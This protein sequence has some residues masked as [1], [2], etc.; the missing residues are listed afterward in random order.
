VA[1]PAELLFATEIDGDSLLD[2]DP[3]TAAVAVVGALGSP[4]VASL[5]YDEDTGVLYGTDTL[6]DNLVS[7]DPMT[8]NTTVVGDMHLGL[9]HASAIEPVDGTLYVVSLEQDLA[10]FLYTVDKAT[11]AATLVGEIGFQS[12]AALDFDPTTGIL[13][14]AHAHDD[15]SGF[16]VTIDTTTAEGVYVADTHRITGMSF[17]SDGQLFAADNAYL[18]G[19]N[20]LVLVDKAL[21]SWTLIGSMGEG[22]VLGLVFGPDSSPVEHRSWG[23]IKAMFRTQR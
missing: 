3:S 8:G 18:T 5:A 16:L 6:T 14:G 17:D 7:I 19:V 21:G 22:N 13:Y 10:S 12:I 20:L 4:V 11:G 15:D 2:V 23:Q 9:V 1:A